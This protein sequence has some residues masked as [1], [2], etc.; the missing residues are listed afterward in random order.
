MGS[1]MSILQKP[2]IVLLVAVTALSIYATQPQGVPEKSAFDLPAIKVVNE[3]K[4]GGRKVIRYEHDSMNQWGYKTPQKDFFNLVPPT[5]P[6]TDAPLFV[7]LH[8]AGGNGNEALPAV[9]KPHDRNFYGDESCY[10]LCPD[11]ASNKNDWWWGNVEITGNPDLYRNDLCPTEKRVLSTV[12]WAIRTF[13]I[14]RNRVYLNGISMGGSGSLGIGLIQGDVFAAI[15]VVVPAGVTHMEFRT[16]NRKFPDPPLLFNISSPVDTYASGQEK[17]LKF[18]EENRYALAFAWGPFGHTADVRAANP[19]VYEYPWFSI[20]K[21][22]A[23]PV[24]THA[25]TDNRYPG[26][27]NSTAPDQNGQ[28]NGYFRW[29]NM[30]DTAKNFVMELRLVKKDE[31]RRPIETPRESVADITLRRLQKFSVGP[32]TKY[33]WSMTVAEKV[34]Q[35]GK[36]TADARGVL[37]IPAVTIADTPSRLK[38]VGE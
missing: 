12:E 30:Q 35:S 16:L 15:S 7:V 34:L 28:I 11:C 32:G 20:R 1:A 36:A 27:M 3:S 14:D 29:K 38:I 8:S 5:K 19:A 33:K 4:I 22:E 17:L 9:C 10:V 25:T 21:N 2:S 31:L 37:T 23:Y 13:G 18:C 26:H 24:F 6:A